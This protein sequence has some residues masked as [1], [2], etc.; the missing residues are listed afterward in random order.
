MTLEVIGNKYNL[1]RE[2]VRQIYE[3]Y[4]GFHYTVI[5]RQRS[6]E[7][8]RRKLNEIE[9]RR[10]PTNKVDTYRNGFPLKGAIGEKKV[11][12]ICNNLNYKVTSYGNKTLDLVINGYGVDVKSAYKSYRYNKNYSL[13]HYHFHLLESQK[14]ADFIICYAVPINK[15]FIIPSSEFPKSQA[16]FIPDRRTKRGKYWKYLEAWH[17]LEEPRCEEVVFNAAQSAF[18]LPSTDSREA[19]NL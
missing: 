5:V 15:F 19:V 9:L 12:D 17:L 4:T 7:R 1:T 6:F 18:T 14:K 3:K 11:L 8:K 13:E 10:N 2:R 16:I